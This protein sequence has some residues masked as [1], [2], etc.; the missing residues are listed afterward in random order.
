MMV[1]HQPRVE[2]RCAKTATSTRDSP[3]HCRRDKGR[4]RGGCDRGQ[5]LPRACKVRLA[6]TTAATAYAGTY[7]A[8]AGASKVFTALA[9]AWSA[10]VAVFSCRVAHCG[11]SGVE[12][13]V[14]HHTH[15]PVTPRTLLARTHAST[16]A[17]AHRRILLSCLSAAHSA[18][19]IA[20]RSL[21]PLDPTRGPV[22]MQTWFGAL[23]SSSS[24]ARI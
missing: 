22:A 12:A 20:K 15:K 1:S 6:C 7:P 17:K 3:C 9:M 8:W 10:T 16:V 2:W 24:R 4:R 5:S 13:I 11:Q 19:R 14:P 21:M 18:R 23:Q